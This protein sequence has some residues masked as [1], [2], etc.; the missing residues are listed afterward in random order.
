MLS[1]TYVQVAMQLENDRLRESLLSLKKRMDVFCRQTEHSKEA[2]E[3]LFQFTCQLRGKCCLRRLEIHF[4]PEMRKQ[5][6]E[7]E[8]LM[9]SHDALH[10]SSVNLHALVCLY[11]YQALK[12]NR[13]IRK[14]LKACTEQYC[15]KMFQMLDMEESAIFSLAQGAISK[16]DWFSLARIFIWEEADDPDGHVTID[17]GG[18]DLESYCLL[19]INDSSE[20][21][22]SGLE[23]NIPDNFGLQS[24]EG[25]FQHFGNG[26]PP[27]SN[28]I[29][30]HGRPAVQQAHL[31]NN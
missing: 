6:P 15:G 16:E 30:V 12:E 20:K 7:S 31:Q 21:A 11:L 22:D 14:E 19:T 5:V 4:L 25:S 26:Q 18:Y 28:L 8:S 29:R 17:L 9:I 24:P 3:K 27:L 23:Y 2:L 10:Q 1:S 13:D